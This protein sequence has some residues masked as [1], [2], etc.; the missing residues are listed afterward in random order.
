M[1]HKPTHIQNRNTCRTYKKYK[2]HKQLIIKNDIISTQTTKQDI[3]HIKYTY[4]LNNL[5]PPFAT[6]PPTKRNALR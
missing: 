3:K 4:T 5:A 6:P 2:T 1:L